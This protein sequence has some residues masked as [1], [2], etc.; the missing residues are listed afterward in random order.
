MRVATASPLSSHSIRDVPYSSRYTV[1]SCQCHC[2]RLTDFLFTEFNWRTPNLQTTNHKE[3]IT[4]N[5]I[6][7]QHQARM[8]E[9][10][11]PGEH[12][13]EGTKIFGVKKENRKNERNDS[14]INDK[15]RKQQNKDGM[16]ITIKERYDLNSAFL[17]RNET[18]KQPKIYCTLDGERCCLTTQL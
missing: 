2:Q 6:L 4:E 18:K 10:T 15:I 5:E 14:I 16:T 1:R 7:R 9:I 11:W 17:S 8:C 13:E 12:F 3:V